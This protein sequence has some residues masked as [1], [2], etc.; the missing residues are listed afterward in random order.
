MASI[1]DAFEEAIQ[2]HGALT[3]YFLFAIPVYYCSCLFINSDKNEL[4]KLWT[5]SIITFILLF[6][7]LIECTTNVRNGKDSVLP[8]FNIFAIFWNG[9][10]GLVALGPSIA[11]NSIIAHFLCNLITN[12]VSDTN[13]LLVLQCMI[14]GVFGAIMLTSYLCYA[15]TFK[16]RDAYNLK[17]ISDSSMD[18]LI[19]IIFMIPQILIADAIIITPITY[20]IWI[21]F[22]IPHPIAIFYWSMCFIFNLAMCGHYLAQVAYETIAVKEN[23][24]RII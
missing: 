4:S 14:W 18:I 2:D 9:I 6:G 13:T 17:A 11:I 12:Y 23:S 1:K 22:G 7:F 16:I 21:F 24:D 10:K 15:R 3:K 5:A 8:S 20:I 19:S